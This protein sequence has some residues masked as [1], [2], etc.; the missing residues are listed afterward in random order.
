M[1]YLPLDS[2]SR[3]FLMP[4]LPLD[5]SSKSSRGLDVKKTYV[6]PGDVT[7]ADIMQTRRKIYRKLCAKS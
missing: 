2:A 3:V 4:Y 6:K 5:S 7:Y 1:L